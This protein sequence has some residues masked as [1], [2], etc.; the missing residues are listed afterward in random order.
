M[1]DEHGGMLD[2]DRIWVQGD[3]ALCGDS[4]LRRIALAGLEVDAETAAC[5]ERHRSRDDA[6]ETGEDGTAPRCLHRCAFQSGFWGACGFAGPE[7]ESSG[8]RAGARSP[9]AQIDRSDRDERRLRCAVGDDRSDGYRRLKVCIG[10][11]RKREVD[12]AD[13]LMERIDAR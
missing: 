9:L 12:V 10:A 7:N 8:T 5:C 2:E 3:A 6:G 13:R 11:R 4:D 1:R